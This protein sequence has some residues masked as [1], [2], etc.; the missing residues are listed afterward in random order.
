MDQDLAPGFELE[1]RTDGVLLRVTG[2]VDLASSP[3][4]ES[5]IGEVPAETLLAIDL[6]ACTYLDSSTLTVFVRAYKARGAQLR[7][8]IP[9]DARIRRLFELTKLVDV[10]TVVS[11][12]AAAFP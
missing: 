7:L 10:L 5:L 9:A 2:E 3:Q 8:V 6:S 12:R 11:T 4:L 1:H